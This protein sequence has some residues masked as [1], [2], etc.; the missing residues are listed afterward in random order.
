MEFRLEYSSK[1]KLDKIALRRLKESGDYAN[2]IRLAEMWP[3][4]I[5]RNGI[6]GT[7]NWLKGLTYESK[8]DLHKRQ[9]EYRNYTVFECLRDYDLHFSFLEKEVYGN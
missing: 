3:Y 7:Y 5:Y 4:K 1:N 9:L 2:F 8:M 6:Y